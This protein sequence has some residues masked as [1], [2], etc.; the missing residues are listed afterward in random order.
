MNN[1]NQNEEFDGRIIPAYTSVDQCFGR[2]STNE[3]SLTDFIVDE[4]TFDVEE[5]GKGKMTLSFDGPSSALLIEI[6][7]EDFFY[8]STLAEKYL[9]L[10]AKGEDA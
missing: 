3:G 2:F 6:K 10:L 4:V 8:L 9:E 5:G 1:K 7:I